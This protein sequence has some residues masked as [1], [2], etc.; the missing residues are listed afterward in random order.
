MVNGRIT[1]S[2]GAPLDDGEVRLVPESGGTPLTTPVDSDGTYELIGVTAGRYTAEAIVGG[3]VLQDRGI[4]VTSGGTTTE[5]F[6]LLLAGA[7]D[8]EARW[9]DLSGPVAGAEGARRDGATPLRDPTGPRGQ[10]ARDDTAPGMW[11]PTATYDSD[12]IFTGPINVPDGL[13]VGVVLDVPVPVVTPDTGNVEGTVTWDD[14][15]P[16]DGETMRLVA[17]GGGSSVDTTTNADGTYEF[18]DV[19]VGDYLVQVIIDGDIAAEQT[20]T[21]EADET[22]TVDFV[23][24]TP[25]TAPSPGAIDGE[26]L[27]ADGSGPVEGVDVEITDGTTTLSDTTDSDGAFGFEDLAPGLWQMTASYAGTVVFD[28]I[29]NVPEGRTVGFL[30]TLPASAVTPDT[31]TIDGAVTWDDGTPVAG[32]TV[33][34][35]PSGGGANLETTTNTDGTYEFSDVEVE[36]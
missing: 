6:V 2:N 30:L 19:E 32:E 10:I 3:D 11:R 36:I 8:G 15:T 14:G 22:T 16:V 5:D 27:W 25:V 29:I 20:A 18:S 17:V 33:R 4:T 12:V 24:P 31:G 9:A 28:G 35:I 13:T 34:L 23:V 21:A 1:W 7:I 26:I